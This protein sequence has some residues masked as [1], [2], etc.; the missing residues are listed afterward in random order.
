MGN[1][2][3]VAAPVPCSGAARLWRG[4]SVDTSASHQQIYSGVHTK[5]CTYHQQQPKL[6]REPTMYG[7]PRER[8][9]RF[10]FFLVA[11]EVAYDRG[12][13]HTYIIVY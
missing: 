6:G 5:Y 3:P 2:N 13:C 10:R 8:K 12:I 1:R 4:H 9:H 7:A 11:H